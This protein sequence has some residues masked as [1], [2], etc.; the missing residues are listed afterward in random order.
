MNDLVIAETAVTP[1]PFSLKDAPSFIERQFPVG[2]ISAEAHK[3]RKANVGQTL[4]ALGSYWK[5]RKP[6]ILVRAVVLGSLL[7]ASDD[8]TADLDIFLK[9]MAMDD[10]AFAR[11]Y[12][13]SPA[14]FAQLFPDYA[15]VVTELDGRRTAW[16]SSLSR[17]QRH[18]FIAEAFAT[19]PY[20]T[21]IKAKDVQRPEECDE[22]D[23]LAPI[24]VNVNRT[25]GTAAYSLPEL[26]EQLG[27]ARFGERPKIADTFCGGGS[28]PFEAA[29]LGCDVYASDL[30]PIACLLTWG[31]FNIIGTTPDKHLEIECAQRKVEE[32]LDTEITRLGIEHDAQGNRAKAF[33]Y[34]LETRCPK[35]GWMVPMAPTWIISKSRK[36]VARLVPDPILMRYGIE[37]HAGVS[38]DE[39]AEAEYGTVQGGR[40]V[41]PANPERSGV[42]IKVIRNDYRNAEGDTR[43]R[44]RAWE[45]LDFVPR[46]DDIFQERLYCIQ[47][48]TKDSF[49]KGRQET[50]FSAIT[51]DDLTRE[52]KVEAIVR[53]NLARWQEDGLVPDMP[54]EPGENT[55]QPIRE[56]GWTHWHHLFFARSLHYLSLVK[57]HLR[58]PELMVGFARLLDFCSRLSVWEN[59]LAKDLPGKVFSNQALNTWWA[60]ALRSSSF[61][62]PT[63]MPI[64]I[65]EATRPISTQAVIRC[66]NASDSDL[67]AHIFITDPPY[68]D[69]VNY[70]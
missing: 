2:R 21:R 66:Q 29:R 35:T 39:M 64:G 18:A 70:H 65:K 14:A 58:S 52:R 1:A 63:C 25:L 16:R 4:T 12:K 34:C 46:P 9:L 57:G 42:E 3:E 56:R 62:V 13:G 44:L 32:T 47:W 6:L 50:Y 36:V 33:L 15:K 27:I 59:G 68:A 61:S 37:I 45:K 11:R 55:T 54:I 26:I 20:E 51:E 24:W 60:P 30:N 17:A 49:K 69:A 7:P 38:A 8:P 22:A 31:A 43:N 41:H 23:L 67:S 40:L 48:I 5:G 28:I 53:S 10:A 19:L